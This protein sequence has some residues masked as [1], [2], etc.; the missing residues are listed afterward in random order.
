VDRVRPTRLD[1][2]GNNILQPPYTPTTRAL[3]NAAGLVWGKYGASGSGT[4]PGRRRLFGRASGP[5]YC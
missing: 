3:S 2:R 5:R 4:V 1:P